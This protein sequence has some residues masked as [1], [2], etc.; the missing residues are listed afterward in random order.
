[1]TAPYSIH[2]DERFGPLEVV[3]VPSLVEACTETWYNQTLCRV[4]DSVVRLLLL[5]GSRLMEWVRGCSGADESPARPA[6]V[7]GRV[8]LAA[9]G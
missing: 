8:G 9:S 5:R 3:D 1:M 4:N 7:S 2:L 6:Q